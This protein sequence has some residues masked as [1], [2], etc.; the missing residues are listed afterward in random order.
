M[1]W[2]WARRA[3]Q[4]DPPTPLDTVLHSPLQ[5]LIQ[6]LNALLIFLRGA[7]FKPP[8]NKP[9]IRIVC[10]SDTHT[11]TPSIPPGDLL[12]HAGDLTN[13]GT[14]KDIQAQ[15][16]WLDSLPHRYKVVIAGNHDS[17]FDPKSRRLEDV[18]SKAKLNFHNIHYLHNTSTQL[19]FKGGRTLNLYGAADI[20]QCGG[21]DFAYQYSRDLAPWEDRIPLST[22]VL[23]THTP[24]RH[25]LDIELGCDSLL[26]EIWR[27]RP[28]LHVFG[29]IHSGHGREALF[30]DE[31]QAALERLMDRKRP[32]VF[33]DFFP[34]SAWLDALRV[35]WYGIKGILWQHLM[36][37]P[38]GA[39]G[40]LLI[41]AALVWQSTLD[42]KNP[43]EVVEM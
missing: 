12:I 42:I 43:P 5:A 36:V 22:E 39:N 35:V 30:W 18:G 9:P 26:D 38:K 17:Y 4:Y 37:G 20:P 19:K 31:G 2:P 23:I 11:G 3:N 21:S 14:A 24:P 25:H 16:D 6:Y 10:I 41:N 27:V 8:K 29:H 1:Q 34:S 32:G 40:S 28:R 33:G 15:L 7:P 13:D